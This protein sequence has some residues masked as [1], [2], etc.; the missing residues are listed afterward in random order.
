MG[1]AENVTTALER[2]IQLCCSIVRVIWKENNL[3]QASRAGVCK[4]PHIVA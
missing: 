3:R 1:E 4:S 2:L